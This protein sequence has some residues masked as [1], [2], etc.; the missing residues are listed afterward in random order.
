MSLTS[1][2]RHKSIFHQSYENNFKILNIILQFWCLIFSRCFS[3]LIIDEYFLAFKYVLSTITRNAVTYDCKIQR[4]KNLKNNYL[5]T[6]SLTFRVS[7]PMKQI[8]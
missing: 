3:L 6:T 4:Y 1:H 2:Y 7:C 5:S 8:K